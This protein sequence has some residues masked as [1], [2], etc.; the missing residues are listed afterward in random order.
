MRHTDVV[1]LD[2]A[3]RGGFGADARG[4]VLDQQVSGGGAVVRVDVGSL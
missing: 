2:G 4:E 1:H 3:A